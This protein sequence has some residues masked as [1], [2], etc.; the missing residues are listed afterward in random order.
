MHT[1]LTAYLTSALGSS[2][3]LA[4]EVSLPWTSTSTLRT[5]NCFIIML[6]WPVVWIPGMVNESGC[7]V[8]YER[9]SATKGCYRQQPT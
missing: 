7:N 2:V 4:T 3:T 6:N 9:Q 8:K 5:G 1:G